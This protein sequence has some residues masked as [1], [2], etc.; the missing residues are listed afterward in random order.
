MELPMAWNEPGGNGKNPDPWGGKN[1]NPPDLDKILSQFFKKCRMFLQGGFGRGNWRP[2]VPSKELGFSGGI[3]FGVIVI[4]WALSGFFIVN[5]AEEAVVLR[6]GKYSDTL[7]PGL[8]WMARFID[9]KYLVDV[10][11]IYSFSLQGD[12]L[13]KS[14][15]QGDLPNQY[16]SIDFSKKVNDTTANSDIADKSKNV[17]NVE[18]N[19]Q[20]RISDPRAY[21]FNLV[22]PD[23]TIQEVAS[24]AL[25]DV[26]GK[27]KLDDV[28]TTGRELLSSTMLE[29]TRSIL[30]SYT[31]GLDIIAVTLRK[32]QAP[33]Q[34]RAAFSDV[35]RADQDKATYVQQAQAYASKVVPLA[36]GVAARIAADANAYRQQSV[37]GAQA[38]I[39][40]YEA[41]LSVYKSSPELTRER[42]YL[43]T[44]QGIY[45]NTSKV[46]IDINGGN[47][48]FYL[49][50]DKIAQLAKHDDVSS[51]TNE[52]QRIATSH[53]D[54]S[55]DAISLPLA[56]NNS[57]TSYLAQN[58]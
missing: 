18:L 17:V 43:E 34:V 19:V 31:S 7:Q 20:Y 2:G 30:A 41:L 14:S 36:Q 46:L 39:A 51:E 44:M 25:S 13:T 35:N 27:M 56:G 33:D 55:H 26:V 38:Q 48:M 11:K 54:A 52:N 9:T 23:D 10:Q 15:E 28:L 4:L 45:T 1:Q 40:K 58:N 21:L 3:I 29:H 12:F 37:L 5:P 32:V 53:A 47:N 24:G 22:G 57:L 8:H 42:M 16:I 50:L 49:P 6:L